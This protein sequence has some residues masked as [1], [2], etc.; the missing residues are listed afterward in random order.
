MLSTI[1]QTPQTSTES[2]VVNV[3]NGDNHKPIQLFDEIVF[4]WQ[5][6]RTI[7]PSYYLPRRGAP[8]SI[9]TF[10]GFQKQPPNTNI[11][12]VPTNLK[13]ERLQLFNRLEQLRH[14][15]Q[16]LSN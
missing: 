2:R 8:T 15:D 1:H 3:H 14:I 4:V 6:W 10:A 12:L 16:K 11:N 7:T 13:M 9:E 5:P